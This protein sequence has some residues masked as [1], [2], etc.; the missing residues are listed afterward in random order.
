MTKSVRSLAAMTE[1]VLQMAVDTHCYTSL[2]TSSCP[3]ANNLN[4]KIKKKKFENISADGSTNGPDA[5]QRPCA[6]SLLL[7][8]F[9]FL[10]EMAL[11]YCLSE[12][13]LLGLPHH[14]LTT[15]GTPCW[16]MP[17]VW[18]F[19]NHHDGANVLLLCV[20]NYYDWHF[21]GNSTKEIKTN[22]WVFCLIFFY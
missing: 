14:F 19:R 3:S 20:S 13:L 9:L 6:S 12:V 16:Q 8:F 7:F 22:V 18:L 4:Q 21:W 11:R 1:T 5:S 17:N 15:Q 10:K 2:L